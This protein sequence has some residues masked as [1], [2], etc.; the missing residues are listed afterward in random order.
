[1]LGFPVCTV[2][3]P[4]PANP[5]LVAAD[6]GMLMAFDAR[7][8]DQQV[9]TGKKKLAAQYLKDVAREGLQVLIDELAEVPREETEFGPMAQLPKPRLRLPRQLP[10]P[11][12][13]PPTKWELYAAQKGIQNTKRE[14]MVYDPE[15][16]EY[17][18]R[19][20]Y[21]V[22]SSKC[23]MPSACHVDI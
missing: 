2:E 1:M 9:L 16:K 23:M 15:T 18:P 19:W 6:V 22:G 4:L 17:R 14:R 21:K 5:E 13:K 11:K 12:P 8:V 3:V 20:G 7:A 10:V